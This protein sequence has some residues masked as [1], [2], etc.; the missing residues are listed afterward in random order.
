MRLRFGRKYAGDD[1]EQ[2]VAAGGEDTFDR[3]ELLAGHH[4]F[5]LVRTLW[6]SLTS[7]R[8]VGYLLFSDHRPR[9]VCD[10]T[11][12]ENTELAVSVSAGAL[13]VLHDR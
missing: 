10:G 12:P 5:G 3:D 8:Q 1:T 13:G 9:S 7:G 6:I 4:S 11:Y 2:A